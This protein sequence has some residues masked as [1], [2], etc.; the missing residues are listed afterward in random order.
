MARW[1]PTGLVVSALIALGYA[2]GN[3]PIGAGRESPSGNANGREF[4]TEAPSL[5][6]SQEAKGEKKPPERKADFEVKLGAVC[7]EFLSNPKAAEKKYKQKTVEFTYKVFSVGETGTVIFRPLMKKSKDD[8]GTEVLI[9]C[10]LLP[11][12]Y[13]AGMRCS[14]GQMVKVKTKIT[15]WIEGS[16]LITSSE[17][18][19]TPIDKSSLLIVNS[20]DLAK[21]VDKDANA[22]SQKYRE[23]FIMTGVV[24]D[25]TRNNFRNAV[26]KLKGSDKT[27]FGVIIFDEDRY[28]TLK[29]GQD[30]ELRCSGLNSAKDGEIEISGAL[31]TNK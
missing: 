12:S 2:S 29:K 5:A 18:T 11:E 4:P 20:V 22:A 7:G 13:D 14:K 15:G 31:L 17:T 23:G 24:D 25:L 10:P 8:P 1:L 16:K 3:P 19:L 28:K 26:V 6:I 9:A 30:V 27:R 21:E